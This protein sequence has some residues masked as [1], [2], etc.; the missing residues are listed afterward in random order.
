MGTKT[1]ARPSP[2]GR[3]G[4][5]ASRKKAP[6]RLRS[7]PAEAPAR[8]KGRASGARS[9]P[10]VG[11]GASAGGLEAFSQL[12]GH[13]P[14]KTGMAFVLVQHL[15]PTHESMLTE[16][17]AK[18]TTKPVVGVKDGMRVEPD[19]VYVIPPNT[20]MA[21]S[22]GVLRLTSRTATRGPYMPIDSFFRSL[23][24]DRKNQA[25]GVILSGSASDGTLGL[26]AIKEEGGITFAQDEHSAKFAG[27]P[28]TA[29]AAGIV[30]FVLS[31]NGIADKLATIGRHP[32]IIPS[33]TTKPETVFSERAD[34]LAKIF[35]MVRLGTGVDLTYYKDDS[36]RRRILRRMVLHR[37][38]GLEHYVRYIEHHPAEVAAL[39]QDILINVTSF[40]REPETLEAL[41]RKVFPHLV[42]HR[43]AKDPIRV[44]VPGC[45]TGEGAYSLAIALLE[46]MGERNISFPVQIFGTD[47]NEAAIT[48]ARAGV[49]TENIKLHVLPER[50][51]R[52]FA[53]VDGNLKVVKAVRDL[54]V[55]ARQDVTKDPPFSR[56]DL[57]S[58]QNVLIYLKPVLQKRVMTIFH[59]ALKPTGYLVLGT[60]ESIGT[61]TDL[62][63]LVDKK[64]KVYS[65]KST[66]VRLNLDFSTGH[67]AEAGR[68]DKRVAAQA[69]LSDLDLQREADRLVLAKYTPAGVIVNEEMDILQFRGHCGPYLEPAPGAASFNLLKMARGELLFALR[70]TIHKVKKGNIL[71]RKEDVRFTSNGQL[72]E[73]NIEVIPIPLHSRERHFLVLFE[74]RQE[75]PRKREATPR[76]V[77]GGGATHTKRDRELLQLQHELAATKEYL[78]SIVQEREASIEELQSAN[79]EVLSSNEELQSTNEELETATEELQSTNEELVT[80]NEEL[81]HRNLELSRVNDDLTNLL[82]CVQIPIIMV[83]NDLRIRRFTPLAEKLFKLIPADV[84]RPLTDL[85]PPIKNLDVQ[86]EVAEVID[87]PTVKESEVQDEEGRRYSMVIRP[88][89]TLENKIDGALIALIDIH[90]LKRSIAEATASQAFAEA[91][92][93]TVREPLLVLDEELRVKTANRSFYETFRVLR[94][95]TENRFIYELGNGQWNIPRLRTL[96]EEILRDNVP[97][98]DFEV[99]YTFERIGRKK[100]LLNARRIRQDDTGRQLILLA[101]ENVTRGKP[102]ERARDSTDHDTK[103]AKNP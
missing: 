87:T 98:N 91:I 74:E 20:I 24:L 62:F 56:L 28:R 4:S 80:V 46:F 38:E 61:C 17:L 50:L 90:A 76:L 41:D 103:R 69:I 83:G 16:I 53:T 47:I 10:V 68:T 58:C 27:M 73:V 35:S 59:Y 81:Q 43:A 6:G 8:A 55:F 70:D 65:K 31:P 102:A 19:R 93:A 101:I 45:S 63:A 42:E 77:K 9:F 18:A 86:H 34:D 99:D 13:L 54:C 32:Y 85:K 75:R 29:I 11:V 60:S 44:W 33:R 2:P 84:G 71:L 57:I 37:I 12:L 21:M 92:V 7:A 3:G 66:P 25:I 39:Y 82:N 89:K 48:K 36:V 22:G 40:F 5:A 97:F 14:P 26:K 51:G 78:R 95:E 100:M 88:Y 64:H 79:E 96:L 30:D 67:R 52:F 94:E 15:D 49:Y 23:A 1:S 72:R